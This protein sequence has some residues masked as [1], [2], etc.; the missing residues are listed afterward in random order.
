MSIQQSSHV[1][2]SELQNKIPIACSVEQ[3]KQIFIKF[4]LTF[5]KITN[6]KNHFYVMYA[7]LYNV[8]IISRKRTQRQT[9]CLTI[10]EKNVKTG[11]TF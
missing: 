9:C 3:R 8:I 11:K 10:K 5:M 4:F 7:N 1:G 6:P 2:L